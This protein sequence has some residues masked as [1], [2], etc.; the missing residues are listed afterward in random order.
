MSHIQKFSLTDK[1]K[2]PLFKKSFPKKG[3]FDHHPK[4]AVNTNDEK[5][6]NIIRV[7]NG[8]YGGLSINEEQKYQS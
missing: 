3:N 5:D 8:S 1:D 2:V 6:S 7:V 4:T